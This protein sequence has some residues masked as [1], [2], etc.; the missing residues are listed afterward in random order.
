MRIMLLDLTK[1]GLK[2][3]CGCCSHCIAGHPHTL[4]LSNPVQVTTKD[5]PT[6][7]VL[8]PEVSMRQALSMQEA[9]RK[10][11][12]SA[13]ME[14]QQG[15]LTDLR[16]VSCAICGC[17]DLLSAALCHSSSPTITSLHFKLACAVP[18]W[19]PHH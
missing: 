1:A 4:D 19:R 7:F 6:T 15:W 3:F 12:P 8:G 11:L 14:E 5:C 16:D 9:A 18:L 13:D 17:T 10:G 2:L